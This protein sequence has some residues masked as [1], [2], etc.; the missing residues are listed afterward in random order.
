MI[1]MESLKH[2]R[3]QSL[4]CTVSHAFHCFSLFSP[5]HLFQLIALTPKSLLRHPDAKSSFDDFLEDTEFRRLI[6]EEGPASE[7]PSGVKRVIFCS[8]KVYYD[9]LKE[10]DSLEL[11]DQIAVARI[12]QV[13]Y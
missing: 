8:G 4:C 7:N 5:S 9:L 2:D 1:S 6:P 11:Q 3:I 10:R 13:S 12:E